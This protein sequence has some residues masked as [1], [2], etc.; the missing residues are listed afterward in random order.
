M[1]DSLAGDQNRRRRSLRSLL[2]ILILGGVGVLILMFRSRLTG[3]ADPNDLLKHLLEVRGDIALV[4][5]TANAEG[6]PDPADPVVMH[7]ADVRMPLS[8]ISRLPILLAYAKAVG[9]GSAAADESVS[10]A[11]WERHYLSGTDGGAHSKALQALQ[12]KS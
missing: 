10:V 12:I 2:V 9:A 5:Y 1:S 11:D 4:A 3:P 6:E 8:A 7:N